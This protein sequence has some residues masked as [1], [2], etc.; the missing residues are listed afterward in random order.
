MS[1]HKS[2][3][4]L[5]IA[6]VL[7]IVVAGAGAL[8]KTGMLPGFAQ[9]NPGEG[10]PDDST[11]VAEQKADGG[12]KEDKEKEV[13]VSVELAF[14]SRRA[15]DSYYRAASV[16][17]A[18]RLVSLVSKT[19]GRIGALFVEEGDWVHK[20]Q[21]LASLESDREEVQL[22][23]AELKLKDQQRLLDRNHAMLE[24]KLISTQEFD[25]VQ[26]R[27]DQ[28][29]AERDLARIAFE[30]KRIVAP[31]DGQ[32]TQRMI[33]IGQMVNAAEPLLSLADFSPLRLRVHL[34]EAVARKIEAGQRVLIQPEALDESLEAEVERVSPVVDP[35][36]STVRVTMRLDDDQRA[37]V[38]GFVKVRITT[39]SHAEALAVPKISLVEEGSLRSVF[40]AEADT[41][42]K[43]EIRTG[44]YD[45]RYVEVLDGLEDGWFVV[46]VG[47]GGLRDGTRIEVLNA[48]E[49]GWSVDPE[50]QGTSDLD[51]PLARAQEQ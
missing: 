13:T 31:F 44:L 41:V 27:Y 26:S 33:V 42:R 23:Q 16:I 37:R 36:T 35:A 14:A 2:R 6:I 8:W 5:L 46:Q 17:E 49:V 47:Q 1:Q 34:P 50:S 25:D 32:I 24:E 4:G 38:G 9:G 40:V 48:D 12:D 43:V 22:R 29:V 19:Q 21:V 20:G 15:I 10:A 30:E 7:V 28:A 3:R 51:G 39:D 18:N 45:E 11:T